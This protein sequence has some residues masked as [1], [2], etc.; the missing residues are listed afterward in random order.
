MKSIF[1]AALSNSVSCAYNDG[2]DF[3]PAIQQ[4]K[5]SFTKRL[6]SLE[7]RDAE[8]DEDLRLIGEIYRNMWGGF[9]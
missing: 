2:H 5:Y 7:V 3:A 6:T 4:E 8:D 9:T 1:F